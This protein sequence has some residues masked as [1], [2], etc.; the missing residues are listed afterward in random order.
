MRPET[1]P[2]LLRVREEPCRH[3]RTRWFAQVESA[4]LWPLVK[5]SQDVGLGLAGIEMDR[6][7]LADIAGSDPA[8]F[9][10]IADKVRAALA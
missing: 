10:A 4:H 2:L 5:P 1:P 3:Q 9:K 7:V 8:G 6:K